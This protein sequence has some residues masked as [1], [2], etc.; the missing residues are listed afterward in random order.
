ML[1]KHLILH[2]SLIDR[3]GPG[4]I[5]T[6]IRNQRSDVNPSDLYSFSSADW[7]CHYGITQGAAEKIVAGLADK[8]IL[9]TELCL[10][11]KHTIQCVSIL[12]DN[13]PTLLREIYTPPAVLYWRGGEFYENK[14]LV[15]I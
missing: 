8:K 6:I 15:A 2:L 9:E 7:M 10:I 3:V 14:K 13:Y 11:E 1:K 5:Q 12:E 4:V